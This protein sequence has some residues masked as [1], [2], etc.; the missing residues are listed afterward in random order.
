MIWNAFVYIYLQKLCTLKLKNPS[1]I[2]GAL[3][4]HPKVRGAHQLR[5]QGET[6][7]CAVRVTGLRQE[8]RLEL[9]RGIGH[10]AFGVNGNG[11]REIGAA[12]AGSA[13]LF[14]DKRGLCA[15]GNAHGRVLVGVEQVIDFGRGGATEGAMGKRSSVQD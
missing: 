7:G 15:S 1:G 12:V 8:N 3:D 5:V 6:Q 13:G 14:G 4:R 9:F 10:W 2:A 11:E